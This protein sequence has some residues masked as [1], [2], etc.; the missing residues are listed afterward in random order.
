MGEKSQHDLDDQL[1]LAPIDDHDIG[2]RPTCLKSNTQEFL[3]VISTAT[4][5]AQESFFIGLTVGLTAVIGNDLGMTIAEIA[6]INSPAALFLLMFGRIADYYGRKKLFLFGMG[7]FTFAVLTASFATSPI[8]LNIFSGVI[9]ICSASVVPPAIG[10]LGA[11]Y[12]TSSV[13]KNRA[14]ACFS[15]GNPLGYVGGMMISGIAADISTWRTSFRALAILYAIFT[16]V[17]AWAFPPDEGTTV[18][19]SIESL[20]RFDV[21]GTILIVVGFASL[22][23]SLSLAAGAPHGWRT[24]YVIALLCLG[25]TLLVCFVWWESKAQFPLMP[26]VI[27][28]DRTFSAVVAVQCLGEVGFSSTT[29]WLS[30]FFQNVRK[31]SAIKIA[32]QLL[33]M[34]I[35]GIIV[36]VICALILHK[37]SN[38]VLMG[39]GTVA[40]TVAFLILSFLREEATYWAFIFPSLILIVIGVDVQYNVTNMYVMNSL[41]EQQ[42]VAGGIFNTITRLC[43]NLSLGISTAIYISIKEKADATTTDVVPYLF[44]FRFA[45]VATGISL[46]LIPLV[47]IGKQ[48][49]PAIQEV[50]SVQV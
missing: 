16:I 24:G 30:L 48:G 9:G 36:N 27:W 14:F 50:P 37:V 12:E 2:S 25:S 31:D 11:V 40:F 45:A 32:L 23:A 8:Y 29:F 6:W 34:V 21:M 35:G 46:F 5:L 13:R 28:Q 18:P 41:P 33:P 10:K 42:S 7:G 15:A 19:L 39:V 22:T 44:T 3:F 38:Q 26:P 1:P 20:R 47:K 17:G 4:A 43:G 49:G